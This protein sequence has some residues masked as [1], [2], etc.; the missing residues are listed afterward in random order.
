MGI[1][2]KDMNPRS[3]G[4]SKMNAKHRRNIS[5][6]LVAIMALLWAASAAQADD[7]VPESVAKTRGRLDINKLATEKV[8]MTIQA[9]E[10]NKIRTKY[11]D[12][13]VTDRTEF[14]TR[15]GKLISFNDFNVPCEAVIQYEP[16]NG[17]QRN[18]T[19]WRVSIQKVGKDATNKFSDPEPY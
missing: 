16:S 14:V 8:S 13:I 17:I 15:K 11:W 12:F 10:H 9:K 2:C 6:V 1:G 7:R 5:L 19:V 3:K 4:N 18:R